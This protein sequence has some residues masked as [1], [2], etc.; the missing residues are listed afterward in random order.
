MKLLFATTALMLGGVLLTTG[1][2][3]TKRAL[4][5]ERV[6]PDEFRTVSKAPLVV[7]PDYNLRPPKPGAPRPQDMTP[8]QAARNAILANA[9]Y[10]SSGQE[11]LIARAGAD[12]VDPSVRNLV[13]YEE[14][15]LV[16]KNSAY[17][18]EIIY[19]APTESLSEEE[20]EKRQRAIDKAVGDGQPEIR[21]NSR[22]KI[23]GL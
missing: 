19:G 7:P 17:A 13:D 4:G 16:R 5:M 15:G 1:C 6:T 10:G 8:S 22:T 12:L 2:T 11:A 14:A 20:K 18:N 23:P 3:G 21:K 9:E